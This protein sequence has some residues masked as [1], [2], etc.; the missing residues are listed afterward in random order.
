VR[1]QTRANPV[2]EPLGAIDVV[3]EARVVDQDDGSGEGA[4]LH[5]VNWSSG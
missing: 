4:Y 3:Q 5:L 2:G 1:P